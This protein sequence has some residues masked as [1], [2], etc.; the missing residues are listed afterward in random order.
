MR[1]VTAI[2]RGSLIPF[3]AP[4]DLLV[5]VQPVELAGQRLRKLGA[6]LAGG[7]L[8]VGR[9]IPEVKHITPEPQTDAF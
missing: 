8:S 5:V 7:N 4:P 2:G 9:S 6:D 1:L 3:A